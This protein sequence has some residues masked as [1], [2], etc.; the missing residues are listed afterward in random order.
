MPRGPTSWC[1]SVW[2]EHPL[3]ERRA[4]GSNPSTL[5]I[6]ARGL[7][8]KAPGCGPGESRAAR[9]ARIALGSSVGEQAVDN[10][11]V[12]GSIPSPRTILTYRSQVGRLRPHKATMSRFDSDRYYQGLFVQWQDIGLSSRER[13]VRFPHRSPVFE[14]PWRTG[15][16]SPS[17]GEREQVRFL[18]AMPTQGC[19]RAALRKRET[20]A[21]LQT[22]VQI[23]PSL[24]D[25]GQSPSG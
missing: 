21:E 20:V 5:T 12:G 19:S 1:S 4:V 18:P 22:W 24:P 11:Q 17:E 8:A 9:D 3:W 25:M 10:R 15:R 16:A 6:I 23:P 7:A 2:L 14:L 13:G